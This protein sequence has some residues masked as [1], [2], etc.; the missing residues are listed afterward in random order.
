MCGN[1]A[2]FH[3][4]PGWDV[5]FFGKISFTC[6]ACR[7]AFPDYKPFEVDQLQGAEYPPIP[8]LLIS[9]AKVEDAIT[10]EQWTAAKMRFDRVRGY[11]EEIPEGAFALAVVFAPLLKRY[12]SGERTREL[13]DDMMAIKE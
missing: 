6:H 8:A 10:D 3:G 12:Q 4:W 5:G 7:D 11:Y 13:Y 9:V 2:E 1:H